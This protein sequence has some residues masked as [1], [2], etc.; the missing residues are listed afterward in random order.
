MQKILI[1]AVA[2][3]VL[4]AGCAEIK[5][6]V[7]DLPYRGRGPKKD[8]DSD[9]RAKYEKQE[10]QG[11]YL[12]V[13]IDGKEAKLDKMV[14]GEQYW[15]VSKCGRNPSIE[16]E[17]DEKHLGEAQSVYLTIHP[18]KGEVPDSGVTYENDAVRK[19]QPD[20]KFKLQG[21]DRIAGGRL[22]RV[23]G[24]PRGQYVFALRVVGGKTWDRQRIVVEV[25]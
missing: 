23:D 4:L 2:A 24:L 6:D 12:S 7:G 14:G 16:F 22:E 13:S 11:H 19:L 18:M 20:E 21:F 8:E 25:K 15:S 5:V 17:M 10:F 3:L 9:T 1:P